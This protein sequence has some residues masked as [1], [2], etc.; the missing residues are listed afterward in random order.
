MEFHGNGRAP[1]SMI[2]IV[3]WDSQESHGTWS[4]PISMTPM[5]GFKLNYV[6]KRGHWLWFGKYHD[7]RAVVTGTWP[8]QG[9]GDKEKK[10]AFSQGIDY[11]LINR[12]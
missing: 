11:E 12:L 3:P 9:V 6:S 10:N 2:R 7:I 1:I 8:S 4:A 5:M